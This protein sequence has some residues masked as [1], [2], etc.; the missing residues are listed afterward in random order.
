MPAGFL[1]EWGLAVL[2]YQSIMVALRRVRSRAQTNHAS[3]GR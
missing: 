2:P 1:K 3:M